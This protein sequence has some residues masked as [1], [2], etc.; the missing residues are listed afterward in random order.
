MSTQ[1]P[2]QGLDGTAHMTYYDK[3]HQLSFVW[4]GTVDI[5]IDVSYGGYGETVFARIPW[6]ALSPDNCTTQAFQ[7]V[8]ESFVNQI[9]EIEQTTIGHSHDACGTLE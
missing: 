9:H 8:C 7:S 4:D 1:H 2:Q 5:W 6:F 3:V